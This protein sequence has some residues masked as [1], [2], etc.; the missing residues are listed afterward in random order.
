[1]PLFLPS[2][3]DRHPGAL[4]GAF[5]GYTFI[6]SSAIVSPGAVSPASAE[7]VRVEVSGADPQTV[8]FDIALLEKPSKKVLSSLEEGLPV[9]VSYNVEVWQDRSRW[10]DRL[11]TNKVINFL[12][13]V[14]PW[15][16]ELQ[17]DSDDVPG[18]SFMTGDE[19]VAWFGASGPFEMEANT[20]LD[21]QHRYDL[22]IEAIVAPLTEEQLGAVEK[23]LGGGDGDQRGLTGVVFDVVT[24]MSGLG[25]LE[26]HGRSRRFTPSG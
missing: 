16:D 19:L 2:R 17:V 23:W 26:V 21:P 3:S 10:F 7:D 4:I 12:V 22:A 14:D 13:R 9:Q 25:G 20:R 1:M 5:L 18:R 8:T 15:S 11:V 24:R 6:V